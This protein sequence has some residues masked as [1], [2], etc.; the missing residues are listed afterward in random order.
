MNFKPFIYGLVDPF[1]PGHVRYV[2]MAT[3]PRRPYE[4]AKEAR[5]STQ[6]THKLNWIRQVQA[7]GSEPS[8]LILEE[9]PEGCDREF[10]GFVESC[11]IKSLREIGHKLTNGTDGGEGLVN[12]TEEVRARI[13]ASTRAGQA[14]E[15]VREKMRVAARKRW[16]DP[17]ERL[18]K[19]ES[20]K[21]AMT[22]ERRAV[23]SAANRGRVCSDKTRQKMREAH[24]G[25]VF[26]PSHCR[27]ISASRTPEVRAKI[28]EATRKRY[29]DPLERERQGLAIKAGVTPETCA[30][31]SALHTGKKRS[32]ETKARMRAA[33][34]RRRG[35]VS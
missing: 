33:W 6:Q 15:D 16:E 1:E 9:L 24:K 23:I 27:N 35:M 10:L 2:G 32:E 11:Y 3:Q 13:S 28:G 7:V 12:P 17:A 31:I 5:K 34:V 30:K 4:H 21:A 22:A 8:V 26:S 19:S 14:P 25:L 20:A 29:E 18:R